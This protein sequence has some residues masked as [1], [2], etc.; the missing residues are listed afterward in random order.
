MGAR[1]W[2]KPRAISR[3]ARRV[4]VVAVLLAAATTAAAQNAFPRPQVPS[5]PS[6]EVVPFGGYR[7]GGSGASGSPLLPVVYDA[8]GGVTFGALVD[9]TYGPPQDG[10]KFE[11]L[12]SRERSWIE[13][14]GLSLFDPKRRVDV[15]I[16][17]LM[18]GGVQE[19]D[20]APGKAFIGGLFGLSR[21]ASDYEADIRLTIGLSA[22]AKFFANRHVGFRIDGRGYLTIVSLASSTAAVACRGGC[23]VA[24]NTNPA[25]Q[26]DLTAGLIIAF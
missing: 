24:F 3:G 26:A 5:P 19:L 6:I 14:Q 15:T 10:L 16:D 22:G 18:L 21:F 17:H 25:L 8:N 12:F 11:V 4:V 13:V 23:V 9:V 1:P 7:V 2:A 20:T